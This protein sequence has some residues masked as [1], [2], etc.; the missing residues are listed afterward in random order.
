MNNFDVY[1]Y[2]F[3]NLNIFKIKPLFED[4][5]AILLCILLCYKYVRNVFFF[6]M[7]KFK[8]SIS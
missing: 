8:F 6:H 4:E 5:Y 7:L 2:A 3:M 1:K